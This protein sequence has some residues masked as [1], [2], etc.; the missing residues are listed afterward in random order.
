MGDFL[1]PEY[2][3][4]VGTAVLNGVKVLLGMIAAGWL[5]TMLSGG[6]AARNWKKAGGQH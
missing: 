3:E 1:K 6:W 2:F 4:A 5:L